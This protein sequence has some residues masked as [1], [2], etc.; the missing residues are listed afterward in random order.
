MKVSDLIELLQ[1]E[2]PDAEVHFSYN[3]GDH[4]RTQVAPTVD[5]VEVGYVVHSAY[6]SMDKV[7]DEE[8]FDFDEDTGE[9]V[10]KGQQVVILG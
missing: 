3:Y 6:H 4:W 1:Q 8:D 2:A 5:S 7:V 10:V 9:P